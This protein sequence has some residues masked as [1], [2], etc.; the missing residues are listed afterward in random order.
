MHVPLGT[1]PLVGLP[2]FKLNSP[3]FA[4]GRSLNS[5][6]C[7]CFEMVP[8]PVS[9]QATLCQPTSSTFWPACGD[10][11]SAQPALKPPPAHAYLATNL[12]NMHFM[13]PNHGL[14]APTDPVRIT[15]VNRHYEDGR[16]ILN[17]ERLSKQLASSLA[18]QPGKLGRVE[19]NLV[20]L[21][22][23]LRCDPPQPN[24]L[25]LIFFLE[26]LAVV[27]A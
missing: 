9:P 22:G 18:L 11:K 15:L 25:F 16:H 5:Q 19:V 24:F 14:Q 17:A 21:E 3:N 2:L 4:T 10:Q 12:I 20:Y 13:A 6:P 26:E 1:Q 23:T 27:I 7:L 8:L